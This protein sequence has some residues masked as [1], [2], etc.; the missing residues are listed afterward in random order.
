MSHKITLYGLGP[1]RSAR[2]QWTLLELGVDF[3]FIEKRELIGSDELRKI[4]PQAKLPAIVIDGAPL[5]ESTAIC[6]YLCD[7]HPGSNLLARPGTRERALHDQW[8]AF[9]LSEMECYLWS[10][11]KHTSFYPEEK[12]VA[13]V[14]KPNNE[15]FRAGATVINS[16]LKNQHFML[17]D[18]FTVTDIVVAWT[19][20]WG[21]RMQ[22]I[23]G[24]DNISGYLSRL[25]ARTHCTLN[26]E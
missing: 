13:G 7:L 8:S 6:T 14:V 24:F 9:A 20:N 2:C 15:E 25:F 11:A 12:R 10:T 5:F 18:T 16:L 21:R 17:G 19:L 3:E 26:Q 4:H 22:L 23:D 1:T